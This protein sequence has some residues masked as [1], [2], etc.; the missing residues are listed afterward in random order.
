[1]TGDATESP[2]ELHAFTLAKMA[3]VLGDHHA[4]R[5]LA[6]LLREHDIELR[7]PA[8]LL[9]LSEVMSKLPGFEGAVGA[10][11]G[12]AAVMRGATPLRRAG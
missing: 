3:K 2:G 5:L 10:M 12:V 6:E 11:L 1:M 7:S 4:R 9:R 8:D